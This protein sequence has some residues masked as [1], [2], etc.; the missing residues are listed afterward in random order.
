MMGIG[1]RI[2]LGNGQFELEIYCNT[3]S[4]PLSHLLNFKFEI[5][6][7]LLVLTRQQFTIFMMLCLFWTLTD[8]IKTLE[9]SSLND[10][11]LKKKKNSMQV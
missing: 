4:T 8:M 11:Q 6:I 2:G 7:F 3:S 10:V 5:V 9:K 1:R